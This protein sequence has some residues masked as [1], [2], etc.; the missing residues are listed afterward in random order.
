MV[1]SAQLKHKLVITDVVPTVLV[2]TCMIPML[3]G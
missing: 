3:L 2:V 1:C